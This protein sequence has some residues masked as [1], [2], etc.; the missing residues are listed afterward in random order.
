LLN[1]LQKVLYINMHTLFN[2]IGSFLGEFCALAAA[3]L[4]AFAS[5]WFK[6]IGKTIRPLELNLIKGA[7]AFVLFA[8]TSLL[9]KESYAQLRVM[10][11]LA[12]VVSGAVGIGLGDTMF[13]ETINRLGASRALL[14]TTLAPP[15]AAIF[16][17]IFM[18]EA[19][20]IW[21][22]L[23]ILVTILGVVWVITEKNKET[24]GEKQPFNWLG[25]FF[26]FMASLSQAAGAVLSHWALADNTVSALQSAVIRL[27]A[28]FLVLLLWI[29]L[30]RQKVGTW[31]KQKPDTRLW[32]LLAGGIL[33]GTY[34]AIWL[35]QLSF[36][37]ADVGIASTLLAT[38]PLFVLPIEA[39]QKEKPSLRAILGV[40]VAILG[41]ALIFLAV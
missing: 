8:L 27:L 2:S 21:A 29:A 20:S 14:V 3:F 11:I 26:G 34:L 31:L 36:K 28:G 17:W 40:I 39:F 13:F 22:W 25:L 41:V 12:L 1:P 35:Q 7:A 38:S 24:P 5:I 37:Y 19:L 16:G 6:K 32:G 33:F 15:M 10:P 18:R 4:W 30:R 9:L 23:G